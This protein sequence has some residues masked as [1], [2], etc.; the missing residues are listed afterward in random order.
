[1]VDNG[2][3][4][5]PWVAPDGWQPGEPL[6]VETTLG[7]CLFN[8]ALPL[9]YRFVNYEVTKKELGQI[10]NDLAERYPRWRSPRRWTRSRRQVST[11]RPAP[12]S[13]SRSTTSSRHRT[14]P[15]FST[16]TRRT[17]RRSRKQ[18]LRGVITEEERRQELVEVWTKATSEVAKEMENNFPKTN[19]VYIMVN[20]GARGT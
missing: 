20:S 14:R 9:D 17:R 3:K 2:V 15:R 12:A 5:E 18:Y 11:G 4:A 1:M 8:E 10:V 16:G 13:R 19:P 6:V 7:R